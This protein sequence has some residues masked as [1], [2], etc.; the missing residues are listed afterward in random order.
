[1]PPFEPPPPYVPPAPEGP[2][3]RLKPLSWGQPWQWLYRA[4]K[5][6]CV[7]PDIAIFYGCAFWAMAMV[8][9]LVFRA[10]P[11]YVMSMASGCLLIGPF[12]AMGLYFVSR[13]IEQ[14][15]HCALGDSAFCWRPHLPSMG[16]L[17][18]VLMVLELLWG[19]ASLVVF[20]VFF[21][22]GM[23]STAGVMEA[24]FNPE[25][26]DF[27]LAYTAVGGIFALLAYAMA[28]VSIPMIL[29]R[30]TDA[31]SAVITSMAVV[32]ENTG[33]ML[34]WGAII[35]LLVAAS[36]LLPWHVGLLLTGP[37]LGHASWHA[38]RAS[39]EWPQDEADGTSPDT[40]AG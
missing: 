1:L 19:R 13:C 6:T 23:P 16:L 31:I 38:Y 17:V 15:Q 2:R 4:W 8:L 34:L 9:E 12:L 36:L 14:G 26:L 39:V 28:A 29:D 7:H 30:G 25:N 35:T 3:K 18:L 22:T 37:L 40:S 20:A 32:L 21:N 33:V 5:D 27:L 24:I 11:E 10:H